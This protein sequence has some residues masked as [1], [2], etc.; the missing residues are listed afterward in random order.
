MVVA[1]LH[2]HHTLLLMEFYTAGTIFS[3][4]SW[5]REITS[6]SRLLIKGVLHPRSWTSR[7]RPRSRCRRK[8]QQDMDL[9]LNTNMNLN[10]NQNMTRHKNNLNYY[11]VGLNSGLAVFLSFVFSSLL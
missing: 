10:Q 4:F 1:P 7:S 6:I 2:I 8:R 3:S 11:T 9:N 5:R